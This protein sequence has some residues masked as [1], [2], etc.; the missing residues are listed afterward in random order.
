[1]RQGVWNSREGLEIGRVTECSRSSR[2]NVELERDDKMIKWSYSGVEAA[3]GT[4]LLHLTRR[5]LGRRSQA[6]FSQQ[7]IICLRE[8]HQKGQLDELLRINRWD[9]Q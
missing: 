8:F 2:E 5:A 7:G 1:M 3:A 9:L 4:E 6:R